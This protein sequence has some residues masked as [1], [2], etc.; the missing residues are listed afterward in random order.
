M[1]ATPAPV[2]V[3]ENSNGMRSASRT[4]NFLYGVDFQGR[5]YELAAPLRRTF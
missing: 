5:C 2:A 4:L 3:A 1:A